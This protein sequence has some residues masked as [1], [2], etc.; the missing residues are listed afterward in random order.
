M[1]RDLHDLLAEGA[2]HDPGT[3]D[4]GAIESRA[5]RRRTGRLGAIALLVAAALVV[6]LQSLPS[7]PDRPVIGELEQT[8]EG[9]TVL[10][11]PAPG[12]VAPDHA[13]GRPVFVVHEESGD[14]RVL[15]AISPHDSNP[16]AMKV[17]AYCST[18][19]WFDDPW[20][21]SKF[22]RNGAWAGGPAPHGLAEH[23][24]IEVT[25]DTV[26]VGGLR[27]APPRGALHP[28]EPAGPDCGDT[29]TQ[30]RIADLVVHDDVDPD[31]IPGLLYPERPEDDCCGLL[32]PEQPQVVAGETTTLSVPAPGE[33]AAVHVD[34]RPVFVHADADP[35]DGD[36]RSVT[37]LD[38]VSPHDSWDWGPRVLAFCT[39][40][41]SGPGPAAT[42]LSERGVLIDL[43]YGSQ[44]TATGLGFSELPAGAE[45]RTPRGGGGVQPG[46]WGGGPVSTGV[47]R[48][49]VLDV[50]VPAGTSA[51]SGG[52]TVTITDVPLPPPPQVGDTG[53]LDESCSERVALFPDSPPADPLVLDDLV[54]HEPEFPSRWWYPTP[55]RLLGD[56]PG[57]PPE[58][59]ERHLDTVDP[60]RVELD[61]SDLP[62]LGETG[63]AV[64][65][66]LG[67]EFLDLDGRSLGMLRDAEVV[68]SGRDGHGGPVLLAVEGVEHWVDPTTGDVLEAARVTPLQGGAAVVDV[69]RDRHQLTVSLD[70]A[71]DDPATLPGPLRVGNQHR[72]V[73]GPSCFTGAD[74]GCAD[75]PAFLDLDMGGTGTGTPGCNPTDAFGDFNLVSACWLEDDAWLEVSQPG[76]GSPGRVEMPRYPGQPAD[77]RTI[78]RFTDA[79]FGGPGVVAQLGLECEIPVVVG[80]SDAGAPVDLWG[81]DR[82]SEAP[83]SHL[84]GTAI[85]DGE[86]VP[87]VQVQPDPACAAPPVVS[88]GIWAIRADGPALLN[89]VTAPAAL[90]TDVAVGLRDVADLVEQI[91]AT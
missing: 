65:R 29:A 49:A 43:W 61:L 9:A 12:E 79:V 73:S 34:G 38:A 72:L 76:S 47:G 8:V 48:Y 6:G 84:L 32:L 88:A 22:G 64:Q 31:R 42:P 57:L 2:P 45:A 66:T 83:V 75:G 5:A 46:G 59:L 19:Q 71:G 68:G 24:V 41:P 70:A 90:W 74:A 77:T 80:F 27:S 25:D 17:L 51:Q 54:L 3:P 20:H 21:G 40:A 35:G 67:V 18:S 26:V 82:W 53:V 36:P 58:E 55:Q 23:E 52:G 78:G 37:V 39:P 87:L 28:D 63:L 86:P 30:V 60:D 16:A 10:P 33:V 91:D 13:N 11:L 14:V 1:P 85:V 15:D 89:D 56:E 44:F 4:L 81:G 69:G 7:P 50:T 62:A